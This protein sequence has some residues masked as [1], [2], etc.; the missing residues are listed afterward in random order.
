MEG[1][2][3]RRRH[4]PVVCAARGRDAR[5]RRQREHRLGPEGDVVDADQGVGAAA[6]HADGQRNAVEGRRYRPPRRRLLPGSARRPRPRTR[7]ELGLRRQRR[8][9]RLHRRP[10]RRLELLPVQPEA[11]AGTASR[12]RSPAAVGTLPHD[13]ARRRGT[14]GL[15]PEGTART[16][17]GRCTPR[18]ERVSSVPWRHRCRCDGGGAAC[19][20]YHGLHRAGVERRVALRRTRGNE[21]G[22]RAGRL[23]VALRRTR[24]NRGAVAAGA[25]RPAVGAQRSETPIIS[26]TLASSALSTTRS[27]AH[28]C[29]VNVPS[30]GPRAF[31]AICRMAPR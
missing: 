3:D 14:S 5:R 23:V 30:F 15:R 27:M 24:G 1:A 17:S 26:A 7:G 29:A 9:G 18:G 21:G 4:R 13:G 25:G 31:L 10:R 28:G 19:S 20:P 12:H 16:A 8:L 2:H 6:P 11:R 22:A